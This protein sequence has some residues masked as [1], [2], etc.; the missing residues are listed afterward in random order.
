MKR[1]QVILRLKKPLDL[2]KEMSEHE[3][4]SHMNS[5]SAKKIK[6]TKPILVWDTTNVLLHLLFKG[7]FL[8][9]QDGIPPIPHIRQKLHKED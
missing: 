9:I 6:Y 7:T 2:S 3:F 8:K 5:L 4:L 1:F